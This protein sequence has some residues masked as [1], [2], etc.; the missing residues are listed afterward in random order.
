MPYVGIDD[1]GGFDRKACWMG[2]SQAAAQLR[3]FGDSRTCAKQLQPPFETYAVGLEAGMRD[4][5]VHDLR[6]LELG[7]TPAEI[8][9]N[10]RDVFRFDGIEAFAVQSVQLV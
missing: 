8:R 1:S 7:S 2:I 9:G 4:Q 6:V 5:V 10:G 3:G